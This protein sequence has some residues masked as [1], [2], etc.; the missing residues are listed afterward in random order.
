MSTAEAKKFVCKLTAKQLAVIKEIGKK[1]IPPKDIDGFSLV[2]WGGHRY[3]YEYDNCI[4][5]ITQPGD[6]TD[7]NQT[8]AETYKGADPILKEILAPVLA[9]APDYSWLVM[10]KV[11]TTKTGL[12]DIA[13]HIILK[14]LNSEIGK[15]GYMCWDMDPRQIGRIG[16]KSVIVDYGFGAGCPIS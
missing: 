14:E 13:A 1:T 3:V 15:L 16:K 11:E 9:H 8:E 2:D 10:P 7:H 12:S 4:V 6:K 5:K